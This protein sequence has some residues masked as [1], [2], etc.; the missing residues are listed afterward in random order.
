MSPLYVRDPESETVKTS[1]F[2]EA[3]M[4]LARLYKQHIFPKPFDRIFYGDGL[5]V[6]V[7]IDEFKPDEKKGTQ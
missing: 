6:R 2:S 7:T 4:Y 1:M 5:R 3:A